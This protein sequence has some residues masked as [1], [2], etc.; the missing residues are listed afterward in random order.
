MGFEH[1]K[2]IVHSDWLPHNMIV[3]GDTITM[4][5]CNDPRHENADTPIGARRDRMLL[6]ILEWIKIENPREVAAYYERR[7]MEYW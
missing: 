5:D 4:I 1:L 7:H 2:E 3:Q 6:K